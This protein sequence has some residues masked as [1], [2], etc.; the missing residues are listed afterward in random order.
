[1][2]SGTLIEVL[3]REMPGHPATVDDIRPHMQTGFPWNRPERPRTPPRSADEWWQDLLPVFERAFEEGARL[4]PNE[5]RRLARHVRAT[6][7]H[8]GSW[9]L[10]DDALPC[11][12]T[13]RLAGWRHVILSNHV[14][15]LPDLIEGLGLA[16]LIDQV[17]NSAQTG[18]EKPHPQ[19][20][21][22]VLAAI[23]GA[24]QIWMVG[25]NVSAD[26]TGAEA[27]G[28][29]SILVRS[30]HPHAAHCCQTLEEV[31]TLLNRI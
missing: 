6:Y 3:R 12:H 14:P 27:V 21:G 2:W 11:L 9:R 31:P 7:L 22:T 29:P 24:R 30:Q 15:E 16:P 1:M 8:P 5:A 18:F 20:F 25:D 19:A 28:L 10:F 4:E 23:P 17:F 26:I 13:L